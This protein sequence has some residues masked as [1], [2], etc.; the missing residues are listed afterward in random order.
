MAHTA[1]Y[2][3]Y[4]RCEGNTLLRK[5]PE[6]ARLS[7]RY[8][9]TVGSLRPF[10][11]LP[12]LA[13]SRKVIPG[14]Q[15]YY[16]AVTDWSLYLLTKDNKVEGS[17]LLEVP[18]LGIRELEKTEADS[19]EF[20]NHD[21]RKPGSVTRS[22]AISIY[23]RASLTEIT[24]AELR[25]AGLD[26]GPTR[27]SSSRR[28]NGQKPP[29]ARHT[30]ST[31][32]AGKGD[33]VAG[34]GMQLQPSPEL[35][36]VVRQQQQL[37]DN[38]TQVLQQQQQ[39]QH[40]HQQ[41]QQLTPQGKQAPDQ[42]S[43][44]PLHVDVM[45][46]RI[47][48]GYYY[49]E[50]FSP[51]SYTV[52]YSGHY[53]DLR[54]VSH[55]PIP[56]A[57]GLQP[58]VFC[59]KLREMWG[60]WH[61]QQQQREARPSVQSYV[62]APRLPTCSDPR[63]GELYDE[64]YWWAGPRAGGTA[65][66]AAAVVQP[67]A[68]HTFGQPYM[69]Y[70]LY[71]M[72]PGPLGD[73]IERPG[74]D[75]AALHLS[76]SPAGTTVQ[77]PAAAAPGP[78]PPPQLP[79]PSGRRENLFSTLRRRGQ[80]G[81]TTQ[82]SSAIAFTGTLPSARPSDTAGGGAASAASAAPPSPSLVSRKDDE[83]HRAVEAGMRQ[84]E[85][86]LRQ[87]PRP[88]LVVQSAA[89]SGHASAS[90][91]G[92]SATADGAV[93]GGA[94][95]AAA[96]PATPP[97]AAGINRFSI[98]LR[99]YLAAAKAAAPLATAA[100]ATP[101]DSRLNSTYPRLGS[102]SPEEA[103]GGLS[104]TAALHP[105][106]QPQPA[107]VLLHPTAVAGPAAAVRQGPA[108]SSP[109]RPAPAS[110]AAVAVAAAPPP[111]AP[112]IATAVASED[113]GDAAGFPHLT[114]RGRRSRNLPPEPGSFQL[115]FYPS[116]Q[117]VMFSGP[118]YGGTA[119]GGGG[120][121][122]SLPSAVTEPLIRLGEQVLRR[123]LRT[124]PRTL[125]EEYE[126]QEAARL[127]EGQQGSGGGG[128]TKEYDTVEEEYEDFWISDPD[129]DDF[130]AEDDILSQYRLI[131]VTIERK[132][133][134]FFHI[135]RA[136][137]GAHMRLALTEAAV[138]GMPLWYA[139][140]FVPRRIV[141]DLP[142]NGAYDD[143]VRQISP[144]ELPEV[145]AA[146]DA[147]QQ[148]LQYF[149][150]PALLAE[151]LRSA[152][153]AVG[154][155]EALG[156][157][158][159]DSPVLYGHPP[160]GEGSA[161]PALPTTPAAPKS[162]HPWPN[163]AQRN[164]QQQMARVITSQQLS[165][166]PSTSRRSL[167]RLGSLRGTL[168]GAGSGGGGGGSGGGGL[169]AA[170]AGAAAAAEQP[171]RL[172]RKMSDGDASGGGGGELDL[173][174][175][176]SSAL[177][178]LYDAQRSRRRSRQINALGTPSGSAPAPLQQS[179][180]TAAASHRAM[181]ERSDGGDAFN[182]AFRKNLSAFNN[183]WQ[184]LQLQHQD[185]YG[186]DGGGGDGRRTSAPT[187]G[188][189]I[190]RTITWHPDVAGDGADERSSYATRAPT[191]A[192]TTGWQRPTPT[193]TSNHLRAAASIAAAANLAAEWYGADVDARE[194][195]AFYAEIEV[196][197][198]YGCSLFDDGDANLIQEIILERSFSQAPG[199]RQLS[200]CFFTSRR[201][202]SFILSRLYAW[203]AVCAMFGS[204]ASRKTTSPTRTR[205]AATTTTTTTTAATDHGTDAQSVHNDNLTSRVSQ[206]RSVRRSMTALKRDGRGGG[207][208]ATAAAATA[209]GSS[210]ISPP[211]SPKPSSSSSA[212][213]QQRRWLQQQQHL[214]GAE[215]PLSPPPPSPPAAS[216]GGVTGGWREG[217]AQVSGQR[218]GD[219]YGKP[220]SGPVAESLGAEAATSGNRARLRASNDPRVIDLDVPGPQGQSRSQSPQ[221]SLPTALRGGGVG[222][223]DG[224][225]S[226]PRHSSFA[227]PSLP[228]TAPSPPSPPPYTYSDDLV[229]PLAPPRKPRLANGGGAAAAAA[230]PKSPLPPSTS[231]SSP[232][233]AEPP[234]TLR[235]K[236]SV[237]DQV[238]DLDEE[239]SFFQ[240]LHN[241]RT[242][243]MFNRGA[244]RQKHLLRR[245]GLSASEP[246]SI[247][248]T[249][250]ALAEILELQQQ[251]AAKGPHQQLYGNGD[252]SG[253]DGGSSGISSL[254]DML[255]GRTARSEEMVRSGM[256][257]YGD[258]DGG[259]DGGGG[260][261]RRRSSSAAAGVRSAYLRAI[262]QSRTSPTEEEL[263]GGPAVELWERLAG[264]LAARLAYKRLRRML[265]WVHQ[266]L[267]FSEG[268]ENRIHWL[269][270]A[271]VETEPG[272]PPELDWSFSRCSRTLVALVTQMADP[273]PPIREGGRYPPEVEPAK[274]LSGSDMMYWIRVGGRS[275]FRI[276]MLRCTPRGT[277][278][279]RT[280]EQYEIKSYTLDWSVGILYEMT[281]LSEE[282][283]AL[284]QYENEDIVLQVL[285]Q[286]PPE[287]LLQ[288]VRRMFLRLACF[289]MGYAELYGIAR[290]PSLAALVTAFRYGSVLLALVRSIKSCA[291]MLA[292]EFF[293]Q[294][295]Y[296]FRTQQVQDR[297]RVVRGGK[298]A[299]LAESTQHLF[300][301]VLQIIGEVATRQGQAA[302]GVGS[303]GTAGALSVGQIT[304]RAAFS[305][306]PGRLT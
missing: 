14:K 216:S 22:M 183:S 90:R 6:D 284:G 85:N 245:L 287:L 167:V 231:S 273:N 135:Q 266:E 208:G 261:G 260:S 262:L 292:D 243:S 169:V 221:F 150:D 234:F 77:G 230:T 36:F 301:A 20:L 19:D 237:L 3:T 275:H 52:P 177:L 139:P 130:S 137:L 194:A 159:G 124:A 30:T 118:S 103:P 113:D 205:A 233:S 223:G 246:T 107:Q 258:G 94:P 64:G 32:S 136:W 158:P 299:V 293:L 91:A 270:E 298:D 16:V 259:G 296:L 84:L 238:A 9:E 276:P 71:R 78:P 62:A 41:Q 81:S 251:W 197:M 213:Q 188:A 240:R 253:G 222:S 131:L 255:T 25:K 304:S 88:Q 28:S 195:R 56:A 76:S 210:Y 256:W 55:T 271:L 280:D 67:A 147:T 142:A 93:Y 196:A 61:R 274:P 143:A 265:Y 281:G 212:F 269:S 146:P 219:S 149:S 303:S 294:L 111:P 38:A 33:G 272:A 87:Q 278:L 282:A 198:G 13:S 172:G 241:S 286:L 5:L 279:L 152:A 65:D 153:R 226:P 248:A 157:L 140:P 35:A 163:Q 144:A 302:G 11:P 99:P 31:D 129:D 96:T 291:E 249:V 268:C 117:P 51:N 166:S 200:K 122:V 102:R 235:P 125:W 168:G 263:L 46:Q 203:G 186:G 254:M 171:G 104:N 181:A 39:Q 66:A 112:G 4:I 154:T 173:S 134:L 27:G 47:P 204:S 202:F 229:P 114:R 50:Y 75:P 300:E 288:F 227:F 43:M 207:G 34:A 242:W 57:M 116:C 53:P 49:P 115:P 201:V 283:Q 192:A 224:S 209:V 54:H 306:M 211:S 145:R 257:L 199:V 72:T 244:R 217:G 236:K 160:S 45:A 101:Q 59:P 108:P 80:D 86:S 184:S 193:P 285:R 2:H 123:Q 206:R 89:P 252:G 110:R 290:Q 98:S 105:Q 225:R 164:Q 12:P 69:T 1:Q 26:T 40:H 215:Q 133:N 185:S 174:V 218:G 83:L 60:S 289:V 141:V 151:G 161:T 132:S 267:A 232:L 18:W 295:Y 120:G 29:T 277:V 179:Y 180:D 128:S 109:R 48:P 100:A 214:A 74:F 70:S 182:A 106:L 156:L 264:R 297:L 247:R 92:R 79:L 162:Y 73:A 10:H 63:T 95:V 239:L 42:A 23:P 187:V 37:Y 58:P 127:A 189:N 68:L 148:A 119:S 155:T 8:Y 97:G 24:P 191:A 178:S 305:K 220:F 175:S 7:L 121:S 170:A 228:A 190:S 15:Y 17:V 82:A 176:V 165:L 21:P 138:R 126:R 250:Q 44:R